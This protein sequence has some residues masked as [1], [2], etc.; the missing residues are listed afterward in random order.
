MS[1]KREERRAIARKLKKRIDT[2]T[3][4]A[5]KGHII[6][7]DFAEEVA[8]LEYYKKKLEEENKAL[9]ILALG[10]NLFPDSKELE[11]YLEFLMINV[12]QPVSSIGVI[13]VEEHE[14]TKMKQEQVDRFYDNLPKEIKRIIFKKDI[15]K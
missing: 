3:T 5:N 7:E 8:V 15:D 13:S 6:N 11:A 1:G 14:E 10:A 2:L 12:F 9:K 4:N